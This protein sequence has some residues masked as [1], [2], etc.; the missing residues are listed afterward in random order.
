[1][2]E[3]SEQSYR[4]EQIK[5]SYGEALAILQELKEGVSENED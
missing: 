3:Q 2:Q 1:M 4:Y 5:A